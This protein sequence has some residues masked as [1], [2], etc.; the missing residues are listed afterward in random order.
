MEKE[1]GALLGGRSTALAGDDDVGWTQWR[2]GSGR[3]R[4]LWRMFGFRAIA[5]ISRG[6]VFGQML[7][8]IGSKGTIS[9]SW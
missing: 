3:T 6:K 1:E 7:M 5:K 4:P 2:I 9:R 8:F